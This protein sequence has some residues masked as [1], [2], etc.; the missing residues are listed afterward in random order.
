M[1]TVIFLLVAL[2]VSLSHM[3]QARPETSC[4]ALQRRVGQLEQELFELKQLLLEQQRAQEAEK[5]RVQEIEGKVGKVEQLE[6]EVSKPVVV[7]NG[8]TFKPYGYIKLDASY[9]DSR[10]NYGNFVIYVPNES[11]YKNDNEFNMTARQTRVGMYLLAPDYVGWKA[12]GRIEIDFYGDGSQRHENKPEPMLRHAYLD[13]FRGNVAVIAGQTSDVISP[14][15]PE[16]LN[17]TVAWGAGNIGYRRPQ[18][19]LTYTRPFDATSTLTMALAA[20][21]STGTINEDLDLDTENDGEDAGFPTIQGRLG[22]STRLFT[23]RNSV[24]GFSGH[25]GKEEID[26]GNVIP[27]GRQV[28][29]KSWSMNGDL[30]FPLSPCME[31]T[32][33][34]FLG[35]NLDDYFGGILQGVDPITREPIKDVGGW[36]QL[37]YKPNDQWKYNLGF[38]IDD[39][40]NSDLS[41][42]MRAR[43]TVI[44]ANVL[45]TLISPVTLGL[46]YSYWDTEYIN[47]SS[48]VDNR[49]HGSV[50]YN[51]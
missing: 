28:R 1:R 39:P 30:V 16:T 14:L 11:A 4:E 3:P 40:H 15:V 19:R 43:N 20:A 24:F 42:G 26:W 23:E 51:W 33:E 46:E 25:W 12:K 21:R 27:R 17:Y 32:G 37:S 29:V 7:S 9:D 41:N 2:V 50:I 22:L 31:L 38:G 5:V 8:F 44:F 10:T 48:G 49:L 13:L 35:Y 6:K 34:A 47:L 45:F 18:L 36:A